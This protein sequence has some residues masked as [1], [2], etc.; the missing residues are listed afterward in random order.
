MVDTANGSK[1]SI[2]Q[3]CEDCYESLFDGSGDWFYVIAFFVLVLLFL[4]GYIALW[5]YFWKW[6]A[7]ITFFIGLPTSAYFTL[8]AFGKYF[9]AKN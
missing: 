3:I 1:S 6:A 2:R 8:A 4:A 7:G 5:I 9:K